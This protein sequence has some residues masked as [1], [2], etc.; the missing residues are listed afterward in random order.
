MYRRWHGSA[1]RSHCYQPLYEAASILE[2]VSQQRQSY[3]K[4]RV[5]SRRG[6]LVLHS[7][8]A[9]LTQWGHRSLLKAIPKW[10]RHTQHAVV[11]V[12]AGGLHG[13]VRG[14][15]RHWHRYAVERTHFHSEKR[16]LCM[17]LFRLCQRWRRNTQRALI[18]L[19]RF[20]FAEVG[21]FIASILR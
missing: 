19:H 20:R 8:L 5:H 16:R 14:A 6:R 18:S 1:M 3:R 17:M 13:V 2:R 11:A 15:F 12:M 7:L 9:A 10:R 21:S 4:W